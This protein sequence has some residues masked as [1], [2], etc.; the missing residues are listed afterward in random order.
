MF[1]QLEGKLL[2]IHFHWLEFLNRFFFFFCNFPSKCWSTPAVPKVRNTAPPFTPTPPQVG[3][4]GRF[5]VRG[6]VRENWTAEGIR[7]SG[8][9]VFFFGVLGGWGEGAEMR[10]IL[11]TVGVHV[12]LPCLLSLRSSRQKSRTQL[13]AGHTKC[14]RLP[15]TWVWILP[16]FPTSLLWWLQENWCRW[17]TVRWR[18]TFVFYTKAENKEDRK[19][20]AMEDNKKITRSRKK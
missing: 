14:S 19:D 10:T 1:T 9:E 11:R 6:V 17:T 3:A 20:A 12:T 16:S 15:L 5:R 7:L 8:K 18:Y 2:I 13:L 4:M